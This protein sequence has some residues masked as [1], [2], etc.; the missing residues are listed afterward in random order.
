MA[1]RKSGLGDLGRER[2]RQNIGNR[3]LEGKTFQPADDPEEPKQRE[4]PVTPWAYPESTRVHAYQYDYQTGQL[5]VKFI[6]YG[7]PW[8]YDDVPVT[9]F[10]AFDAAPSKGRYINS[11][12]NYMGHRRATPYEVTTH[13]VGL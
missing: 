7:T 9:V 12:L 2:I 3:T 5:R 11:T 6:K 4:F 13:F 1:T 8:V 10:E